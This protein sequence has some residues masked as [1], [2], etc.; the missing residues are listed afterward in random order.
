LIHLVLVRIAFTKSFLVYEFPLLNTKEDIL[1]NAC[2]QTVVIDIAIDFQ[3][4]EEKKLSN[5][6][7]QLFG[8]RHSSKYLLLKFIQV[9]NNMRMSK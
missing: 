6:V 5:G 7:P 2:N 1:K 4:M 9:W 3:S 8:D